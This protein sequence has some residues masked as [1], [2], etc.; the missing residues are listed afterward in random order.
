MFQSVDSASSVPYWRSG[1]SSFVFH[2]LTCP[3]DLHSIFSSKGATGGGGILMIS[4]VFCAVLQHTGVNAMIFNSLELHPRCALGRFVE[5]FPYAIA[6]FS[7]AWVMREC[8]RRTAQLVM[9][10]VSVVFLVLPYISRSAGFD[11]SCLGFG[12]QGVEL[13]WVVTGASILL[14][15]I[16]DGCVF[17]FGSRVAG[18]ASCTAGIYYIHLLVGKCIEMPLGRHRGLLEALVVVGISLLI[19]WL[20]KRIRSLS[21][22]VK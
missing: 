19:V 11:L 13:F 2:F 3:F 5:L 1:L 6:G 20:M 9:A 18:I 21:W 4:C 7:F 16:G 15:L 10:G 8:R 22:L 14:I 12:Y 17:K